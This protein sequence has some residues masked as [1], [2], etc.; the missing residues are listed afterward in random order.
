MRKKIRQWLCTLLWNLS[1]RTHIG[2]GRFAPAVFEGMI[3]TK[4][5]RLEDWNLSDEYRES[6]KAY[7]KDRTPPGGGSGVTRDSL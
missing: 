5:Y 6:L 7:T 2:L 1:E 3:G 4:G